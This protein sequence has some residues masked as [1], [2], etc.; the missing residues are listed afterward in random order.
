MEAFTLAGFQA[1]KI[2]LVNK[3][4]EWSSFDV[5]KKIKYALKKKFHEKIKIGHAGTL[6]PLATGLLL[7]CTGKATKQ[8]TA[9]QNLEKEYTGTMFIGASTPSYDLETAVDA[10]FPTE[11]ITPELIRQTALQFL[12]ETEQT[13]PV[14]SAV[15]VDGK[16]AYKKAR[17]GHEVEIPS[18]KVRL[19]I[20]EI[21]GIEMPFV[22]FHVRCSKGT[23]IR[24]LVHDF[25]KALGSGAYLHA[26]CR[27][28]I[29]DYAIENAA[30]LN[31][32][33]T[34]LNR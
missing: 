34:E 8:L 5:V 23:Y 12:G 28:K 13:P 11:Q 18:R 29:G 17:K 15:K 30:E 6:D 26:L 33:L 32:L 22:H 27:T 21:T 1:G 7:I 4:Y 9:F 2:L 20:F 31:D 3:P 19:D 14:F 10:Q 24:S 16:R 25:G